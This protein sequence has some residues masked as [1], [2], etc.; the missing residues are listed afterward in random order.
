[1]KRKK[2]SPVSVILFGITGMGQPYLET[3][4][5]GFSP[6]E[7]DLQ[8]VVEPYP[9]RSSYVEELR[10]RK[11]PILESIDRVYEGERKPELLVVCSPIHH[12]VPQT[13]LALEYGSHVLCEKPI[14][15]TIQ[16]AS[17]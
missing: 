14:G 9:E 1:M 6:G 11:I 15:A 12:H 2:K 10:D 17:N 13:S 3:L 7:V 8:A 4:L 5:A 16:D